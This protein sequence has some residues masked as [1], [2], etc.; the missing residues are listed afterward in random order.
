[1]FRARNSDSITPLEKWNQAPGTDF[2]LKSLWCI[3]FDA[4]CTF[5]DFHLRSCTFS[6]SHHSRIKDFH[7]NLETSPIICHL[8]TLSPNS[9][10]STVGVLARWI[11]FLKHEH[12]FN[13]KKMDLIFKGQWK[14]F[15]YLG[16]LSSFRPVERKVVYRK[17]VWMTSFGSE[18]SLG[19]DRSLLLVGFL[20]CRTLSFF[21]S[22]PASSTCPLLS[23][24]SPWRKNSFKETS[25]Y[26]L[27]YF[28]Q[29]S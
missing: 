5:K 6:T 8:S 3:F 26:V 18:P 17:S 19:V 22:S 23:T 20:S 15:Q 7:L 2:R 10:L 13:N 9:P 25:L 16:C 27:P 1:M 24:K 28:P 4:P 14:R 12:L 29:S 21:T 11:A